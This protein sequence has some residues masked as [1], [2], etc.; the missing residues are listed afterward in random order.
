MATDNSPDPPPAAAPLPALTVHAY[1]TIAV[2]LLTNVFTV[3]PV[4]FPM[5]LPWS[6]A[7]GG[8]M[9]V[10]LDYATTAFA[11]ALVLLAAGSMEGRSLRTAVVGH[12]EG[13]QPWQILVLFYSMN[14]LCIS[15]DLTGM[16]EFL[17]L[18][19]LQIS[20]RSGRRLLVS[21][22]VLAS[23][24]TLFT[25]NDVVIMTLSPL[26]LHL[27][28]HTRINPLP[29]LFVCFFAANTLS[30]V[31][32]LGNTT[33]VVVAMAMD[34]G[35]L[36]FSATMGLVT[37][38]AHVSTLVCTYLYFKADI[39]TDV[40]PIDLRPAHAIRDR[41]AG[42]FLAAL[43]V[44][45]MALLFASGFAALPVWAITTAAAGIAIFRDL[46]A[47]AVSPVLP[48]SLAEEEAGRLAAGPM[49]GDAAAIDGPARASFEL[50]AIAGTEH[51]SIA[52]PDSK[53]FDPTA[54]HHHHHHH[55][56]AAGPARTAVQ[57][58]APHL[59]AVGSTGHH[60]HDEK[61]PDVLAHRR[62]HRTSDAGISTLHFGEPAPHLHLHRIDTTDAT[63][64][65]S[66][67][68]G[69]GSGTDF[70]ASPIAA[71]SVNGLGGDT[72]ALA[73]VAARFPRIA[74]CLDRIPWA[75]LPFLLGEFA[76]VE[77]LDTTQVVAWLGAGAAYGLCAH[78]PLVAAVLVTLVAAVGSMGMSNLPLTLLLTKVLTSPAFRARVAADPRVVRA[79]AYAVVAGSNLGPTLALPGCLAGL[80]WAQSLAANGVPMRPT[81]F[82]RVGFSVMSVPM[83]LSATVLG[84][85]V[86]WVVV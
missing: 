7:H 9:R 4:S 1:L 17:S 59:V 42:A 3:H 78:G 67:G 46:A 68:G 72:D 35:T 83:L 26:L 37:L 51:D 48:T 63:S 71:S 55:H 81:S 29:Y 56:D 44:V 66:D 76:M 54:L 80:I 6:Q 19:V 53:L 22:F 60:Q 8:V 31:W 49:P 18:K 69:A 61:S 50:T 38:V 39:P 2:F 62:R 12:P 64:T 45:C 15:L 5:R 40:A 20:G 33:N 47:D 85:V 21:V 11:G 28:R 27:A 41:T 36:D 75:V 43:T 13:L 24:L 52:I 23:V 84:V 16:L 86:T 32:F 57:S 34:L 25:S 74:T 14:Y 30:M 73:R 82:S 58:A 10:R 79:A 70:S 65:L 77:A